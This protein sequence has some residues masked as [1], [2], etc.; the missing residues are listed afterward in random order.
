MPELLDALSLRRARRAFSPEPVPASLQRLL[1][2]AVAVAPSH[3]NNQPTRLLVTD[4]PEGRQRLLAAL[5]AG[6]QN[7]AGAAPLLVAVASLPGNDTIHSDRDGGARHLWAF[8]AGIAT[9][10]LLAQATALGLIAHP[11]AGFDAGAVRA[12]FGAPAH[13]QVLAMLAIGF[14]G[15]PQSLPEDLR[16]RETGP[17]RRL[18]LDVLIGHEAWDDGMAI[19][20]REFRDRQEGTE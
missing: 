7:W 12:A 5:S 11:M 14:P 18:P 20:M 8:H 10:N 3:G 9:G 15:P 16:R 6:N 2:E 4:S 13:L 1:W 17:Q 19:T